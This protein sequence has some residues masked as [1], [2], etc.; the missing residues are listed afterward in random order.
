[1]NV[2]Q[3]IELSAWWTSS[4]VGGRPSGW[5][6]TRSGTTVMFIGSPASLLCP[7]HAY[8]PIQPIGGGGTT[9]LQVCH[10]TGRQLSRPE[11]GSNEYAAPAEA[12]GQQQIACSYSGG[13]GQ[14]QLARGQGKELGAP[15]SIPG[16]DVLRLEQLKQSLSFP[17]E[18]VG[19]NDERVPA[20][21]E[22]LCS[23]ASPAQLLPGNISSL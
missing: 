21:K 16:G 5:P 22:A 6:S 8:A 13:H 12:G 15:P 23:W 9:F 3:A 18:A 4:E 19:S 1:M 7:L 2:G 20:A 10:H 11:C 14:Q 17:T